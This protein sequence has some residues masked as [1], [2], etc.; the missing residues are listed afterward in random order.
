[1]KNDNKQRQILQVC[2]VLFNKMLP[3][4]LGMFVE[5][6]DTSEIGWIDSIDENI[7]TIF[8]GS[9]ETG[10]DKKI[11]CTREHVNLLRTISFE[12]LRWDEKPSNLDTILLFENEQVGLYFEYPTDAR[13]Y[14]LDHVSKIIQEIIDVVIEKFKPTAKETELLH[15]MVDEYVRMYYCLLGE[16]CYEKN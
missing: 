4:H 7:L 10:N 6:R 13:H 11:Q 16:L 15:H 9:D 1:M 3:P 2:S 14:N 12:Q 8:L 5:I